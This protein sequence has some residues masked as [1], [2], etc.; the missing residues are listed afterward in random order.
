MVLFFFNPNK[1]DSIVLLLLLAFVIITDMGHCNLGCK[2]SEFYRDGHGP[3]WKGEISL[4][5]I[6]SLCLR[7]WN[8]TVYSEN[9]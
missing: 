4:W 5:P 8:I 7:Q 9:S 6:H 3:A 1:L 2:V